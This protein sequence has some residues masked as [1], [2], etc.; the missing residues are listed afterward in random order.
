MNYRLER[1]ESLRELGLERW[2]GR[3]TLWPL[4]PVD[5]LRLGGMITK[6]TLDGPLSALSSDYT[7]RAE[8]LLYGWFWLSYRLGN[9]RLHVKSISDFLEVS[10]HINLC[11]GLRKFHKI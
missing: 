2:V 4:K 8:N 7:Y 9:S 11:L 6:T 3:P 1:P 5:H 10:Q